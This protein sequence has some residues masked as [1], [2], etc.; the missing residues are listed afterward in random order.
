LTKIYFGTE[1]EGIN[2]LTGA[3]SYSTNFDVCFQQ[4]FQ[5]T[6]G[7]EG[8][9]GLSQMSY[10]I[11]GHVWIVVKSYPTNIL[12]IAKILVHFWTMDNILAC[13]YSFIHS[14]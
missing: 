10:I 9:I 14:S 2:F 12:V 1:G 7:I 11:S 5:A 8:S 6:R 4:Q 13:Q 3:L